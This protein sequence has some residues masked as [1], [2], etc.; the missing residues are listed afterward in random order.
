MINRDENR[1]VNSTHFNK[2][3]IRFELSLTSPSDLFF[4][5]GYSQ[6]F[7][8]TKKRVQGTFH[9]YAR[10]YVLSFHCLRLKNEKKSRKTRKRSVVSTQNNNRFLKQF[11][12]TQF[13]EYIFKLV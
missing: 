1:E 10:I 13:F 5:C 6:L 4:S 11:L 3:I 9:V 8:R 12:Q 2:L 7:Q